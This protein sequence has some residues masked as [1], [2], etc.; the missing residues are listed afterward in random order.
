M[1]RGS[2]LCVQD[3]GGLNVLSGDGKLT[4]VLGQDR[5]PYNNLKYT[6]NRLNVKSKT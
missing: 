5:L 4:F 6:L 3:K 1:S 2:L